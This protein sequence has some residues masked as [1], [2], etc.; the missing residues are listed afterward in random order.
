VTRSQAP[1]WD[2]ENQDQTSATAA[3][4]LCPHWYGG[5]C[6]RNGLHDDTKKRH[7][8]NLVNGSNTND[9]EEC[10][11]C[12]DAARKDTAPG[13]AACSVFHAER[14]LFFE[15][16]ILHRCP[17]STWRDYKRRTSPATN[18]RRRTHRTT[19]P[20]ESKP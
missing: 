11:R 18:L 9:W 10:E 5:W 2:E 17:P 15:S 20:Q 3:S 8:C 12:A 6:K 16:T 7:N 19:T 4:M 14:C 1:C 13:C